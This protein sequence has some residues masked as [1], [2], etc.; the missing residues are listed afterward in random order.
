MALFFLLNYLIIM[1]AIDID[2]IITRQLESGRRLIIPGFGAFIY[3]DDKEIVFVPFLK[4]NDGVLVSLLVSQGGLKNQEA[5]IF[6]NDFVGRIR[7]AID[8][9]GSFSIQGLGVL[10]N[11]SA[12]KIYLSAFGAATA[13][14]AVSGTAPVA[15]PEKQAPSELSAPRPEASRTALSANSTPAISTGQSGAGFNR[16]IEPPRESDWVSSKLLDDADN[17]RPVPHSMQVHSEQPSHAA[18]QSGQVYSG[19]PSHHTASQHHSATSGQ[20]PHHAT[21]QPRSANAGQPH[22]IAPPPR[23]ANAGQP[24]RQTGQ[25]ASGQP[26]RQGAPQPG[27]GRNNPVPPQRRPVKQAPKSSRPASK[28]DKFMIVAIIVAALALTVII[29]GVISTNNMNKMDR[30]LPSAQDTVQIG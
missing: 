7:E 20:Q 1:N 13:S 27:R 15:A 28:A 26:P 2:K 24:P 8:N 6:I 17:S 21:P 11:D 5:E 22:H 10:K 18:P 12:G 16:L 9:K 4:K 3:K 25:A 30:I 19:R 14:A 23:P 29:F